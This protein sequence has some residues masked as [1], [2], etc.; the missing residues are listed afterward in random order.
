MSGGTFG[1]NAVTVPQL[2]TGVMS[3]LR[4][5]VRSCCIQL[6]GD[7][8]GDAADE[9]FALL[10]QQ[11]GAGYPSYSVWFAPWNDAAQRHDAP[12]VLRSGSSAVR[13]R[14]TFATGELGHAGS[15]Q[16]TGDLDIRAKLMPTPVWA[17]NDASTRVFAA[18]YD[19]AGNQRSWFAQVSASGRLQLVWSADGTNTV[20]ATSTA[21]LPFADG[22]PGWVR[23]V[24]DV[25]NGAAG[26]DCLFYWA[27]DQETEPTSW[28]QLG[29]TVTTA[30]VT[31]HFASTAQYTLGGYGLLANPWPGDIYWVSIRNGIDGYPVTP[32]LPEWW[33]L[34]GGAGQSTVTFSGAPILFLLNSSQ[35]GQNIAYWDNA[36]RRVKAFPPMNQ[37]CVL[38]STGHNENGRGASFITAY[39]TWVNNIR[40][41][42]PQVCVGICSQNPT[43]LGSLI[44]SQ[45]AIDIRLSRMGAAMT[46]AAAG[47]PFVFAVDTAKA[48]TDLSS[49]IGADGLHPNAVGSAAWARWVRSNVFTDPT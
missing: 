31:S 39:Q 2:G 45:Q 18:K 28:T 24:H 49:Q 6:A 38:L 44:T 29:T 7:S 47:L 35:S 40:T 32:Y 14:A 36:T 5:G 33:D 26:N 48:F 12:T 20:T 42:L 21:V 9:W 16:I 11:L 13:R 27:A 15:G 3:T 37:A 8:T 34:A 43:R 22:Q 1:R 23:I 46:W 4:F 19:S 41:L 25:D 30:A 10:G 17:P